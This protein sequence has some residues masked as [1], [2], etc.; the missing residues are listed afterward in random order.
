MYV[1]CNKIGNVA[2]CTLSQQTNTQNILIT[3]SKV[4]R[5]QKRIRKNRAKF[6][7]FQLFHRLS[8]ALRQ[9]EKAIFCHRRQ[10]RCLFQFL[11]STSMQNGNITLL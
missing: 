11:F 2:L 6:V 3:Y 8:T 10:L 9:Q 4:E 5:K 1:C 7:F